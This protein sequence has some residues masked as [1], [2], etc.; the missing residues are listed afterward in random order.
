MNAAPD[1]S[2]SLAEPLFRRLAALA[3][4]SRKD[5]PDLRRAGT[6]TLALPAR[7]EIAEVA[8][9]VQPRLLVSGWAARQRVLADGRRQIVGFVLPGDLVGFELHRI[10]LPYAATQ[11]LTP[12]TLADASALLDLCRAQ[13]HRAPLARAMRVLAAGEELFLA[14][15]VTR[16]GRQTAYERTS[17]LLLELHERL[18]LAGIE[19]GDGF[20]LP[21]TQEVLADALGISVVHTNRTLQQLRRDGLIRLAGTT[22]T[23]VERAELVAIADYVSLRSLIDGA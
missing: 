7:V 5:M 20:T 3:G 4:L 9:R 6:R 14:H 11:A 10:H 23:L 17:H 1:P 2:G 13:D 16:L 22:L 8:G 21:V 18:V 12:A 15:H 19:T